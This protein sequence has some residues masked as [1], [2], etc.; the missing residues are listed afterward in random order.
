MAKKKNWIVT[1]KEEGSL[2]EVQKQIEEKGF[3]VDQVLDQIGCLTG[4]ASEEVADQV[5]KIPEV[6]DVSPDFSIDI[7]PPDAPVTW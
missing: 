2:P 5:R 1:I 3:T 6:E 7:G 4:S